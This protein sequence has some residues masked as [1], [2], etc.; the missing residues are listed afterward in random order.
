MTSSIMLLSMTTEENISE[1]AVIG[2]VQEFEDSTNDE[3]DGGATAEL[4]VMFAAV[5]QSLE[6]L[7]K[8]MEQKGSTSY[9]MM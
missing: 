1:S 9:E 5:K 3:D 8:F 6:T 4:S 7:R 2:N